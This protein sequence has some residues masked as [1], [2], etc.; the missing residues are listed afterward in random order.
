MIN[1]ADISILNKRFQFLYVIS[2]LHYLGRNPSFMP[3]EQLTR[4]ECNC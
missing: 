1:L 4:V 3:L 2:T